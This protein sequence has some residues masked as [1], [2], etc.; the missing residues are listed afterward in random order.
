MGGGVASKVA[1]GLVS[2]D[3]LRECFLVCV[4]GFDSCKTLWR[5]RGGAAGLLV[6]AALGTGGLWEEKAGKTGQSEMEGEGGL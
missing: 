1:V 4:T 5:R 3:G 2:R 6:S